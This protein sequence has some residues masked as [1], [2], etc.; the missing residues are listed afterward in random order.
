MLNVTSKR[1]NETF[2]I[3]WICEFTETWVVTQRDIEGHINRVKARKSKSIEQYDCK[4]FF[5]L[6][7]RCNPMVELSNSTGWDFDS[8]IK[9]N[10]STGEEHCEWFVCGAKVAF[11][12]KQVG[13]TVSSFFFPRPASCSRQ[14][15]PNHEVILTNT[16]L[17]LNTL[18]EK[19]ISWS[20][21]WSISWHLHSRI[22]K[23][24]HIIEQPNT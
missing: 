5:R 21:T 18:R 14:F 4:L 13:F 9:F 20:R 16:S 22:G 23:I 12:I 19:M 11:D 2:L 3:T 6:D 17:L 24:A 8:T 10:A 15:T 7:G 1:E